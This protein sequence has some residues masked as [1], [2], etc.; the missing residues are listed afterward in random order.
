SASSYT[1][2]LGSM[3]MREEIDALRTMG[4]DPM[5]ILILP[6]VVALVLALPALALIGA[7]TALFGAFLVCWLSAGMSPEIFLARLRDAISVD[8]FIVGMVKAP[9][10]A[11][12]IGI[13]AS[14]EGLSV[15]G[16]AESLGLHTTASV[17]KSIFLVVV[18]DGLFAVF[19]AAVGM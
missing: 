8:D 17:V 3:K 7:I 4:F 1:A 13:V 12:M 10:I 2:E 15:E 6:R 9:F 18:L 19:F 5:E 16:S 11:L 14:V